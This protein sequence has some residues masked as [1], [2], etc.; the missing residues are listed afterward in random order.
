MCK[1]SNKNVNR[2]VIFQIEQFPWQNVS[3][4]LSS[5]SF[6]CLSLSGFL[7]S[8]IE[9]SYVRCQCIHVSTVI[10]TIK[11]SLYWHTHKNAQI[12]AVRRMHKVMRPR[13]VVVVDVVDYSLH[14]LSFDFPIYSAGAAA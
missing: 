9:S 3:S 14:L 12:Y 1:I 10:V 4:D 5:I 11:W 2:T 6:F 13:F 8:F 7:Q